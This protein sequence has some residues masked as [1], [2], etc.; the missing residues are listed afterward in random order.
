MFIPIPD[1][2]DVLSPERPLLLIYDDRGKTYEGQAGG[3]AIWHPEATGIVFNLRKAKK[4][5]RLLDGPHHRRWC[6][7]ID[8]AGLVAID[9]YFSELGMPLRTATGSG[10]EGWV[11][12][13]VQPIPHKQWSYLADYVG[14]L[15]VLIWNNCD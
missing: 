13:R 2:P 7:W 5:G 1:D 6:G 9:R 10:S 14:Q 8:E 12:I 3:V 4:L 15:G 11:H